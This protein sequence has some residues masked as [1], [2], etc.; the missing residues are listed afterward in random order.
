MKYKAIKPVQLKATIEV[1]LAKSARSS[2]WAKRFWKNELKKMFSLKIFESKTHP[3]NVDNG[4]DT[5]NDCKNTKWEEYNE[6]H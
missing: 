2:A 5:E 1:I 4:L 6:G 3:S